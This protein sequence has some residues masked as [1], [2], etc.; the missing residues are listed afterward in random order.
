M[1]SRYAISSL[2]MNTDSTW[3]AAGW[4][5]WWA[6]T[7]C[8]CKAAYSS[9]NWDP[10]QIIFLDHPTNSRE[11]HFLPHRAFQTKQMEGK[12]LSEEMFMR[13]REAPSPSQHQHTME[14]AWCCC[15]E[16]AVPG[17]VWGRPCPD[18]TCC[19][20][21]PWQ[22]VK[23]THERLFSFRPHGKTFQE[24]GDESRVQNNGKTKK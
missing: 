20:L 8:S 2:F 6:V 22:L 24:A 3:P 7:F 23:L 21:Q 11:N 10:S 19:L 14:E 5:G 15:D 17:C 13:H 12:G 1:N 9:R 18:P 4:T 16:A